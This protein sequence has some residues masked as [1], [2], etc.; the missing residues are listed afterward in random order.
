MYDKCKQHR[1]T[2]TETIFYPMCLGLTNFI[3]CSTSTVTS[4]FLT[5]K[6][7]HAHVDTLTSGNEI[8]S[9]TQ[10]TSPEEV[11]QEEVEVVNQCE[12]LNCDFE[13]KLSCSL[14]SL[15]HALV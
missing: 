9:N 12:D 6:L 1:G 3:T 10:Q 11:Q 7:P 2:S 8:Q 5:S 13:H 15:M 14:L 4:R